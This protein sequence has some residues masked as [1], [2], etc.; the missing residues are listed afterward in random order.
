M[1]R[2]L[3]SSVVVFGLS[4]LFVS[5]VSADLGE[6]L[7]LHF[8]FEE[9]SGAEVIDTSG[10]GNN[11]EIQGG[12]EIVTGKFGQGL[13]VDGQTQS[14]LI[15]HDESM[16]ATT[17]VTLAC[18]AKPATPPVNIWLY[19]MI[20]K[21]NYHA[22]DGRCYFIGLLDGAGMTFFVSSD[23]TDGGM[24]RLDGG[25]IEYGTDRWQHIAGT[26]D[27]SDMRIYIDGEEV[28]NLAWSDQIFVHE[29]GMSVGAGSFGREAA[30]MF[31]GTIDEVAVYSRGLSAD[32]IGQLMSGPLVAAV[33]PAE[34]LA[35]T[36]G[37]IKL[38][39]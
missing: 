21:W 20:S 31:A 13:E 29:E 33:D 4:V 9:G 26:Y 38:A 27:G 17:G 30:A 15:P 3:V 19:Y 25:S 18:W 28:G 36:W 24:A 37:E 23:G 12:A 10:N 39:R 35:A 32:E 16:D 22:G 11:G 7:I 5:V 8:D 1:M 6:G 14:I 2:F 34:K